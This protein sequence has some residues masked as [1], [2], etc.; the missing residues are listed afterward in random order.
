MKIIGPHTLVYN[1][2]SE[3]PI[4]LLGEQHHKSLENINV[5]E[6]IQQMCTNSSAT[7]FVER[8]SEPSKVTPSATNI[9]ARLQVPRKV[10]VDMKK[11]DKTFNRTLFSASHMMPHS[12]IFAYRDS[13]AIW[14]E[15]VYVASEDITDL[16]RSLFANSVENV[17]DFVSMMQEKFRLLKPHRQ[18]S[19]DFTIV[20]NEF[21]DQ[22]CLGIQTHHP[23]IAT[24]SN[25]VDISTSS[26]AR[27]FAV[28]AL[29][30]LYTM[31]S[32]LLADGPCV[33]YGG[34]THVWQMQWLLESYFKIQNN[35]SFTYH[36]PEVNDH[37]LLSDT[38]FELIAK[39]FQNFTRS[40]TPTDQ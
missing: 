39:K 7:L 1:T 31:E 28:C 19:W 36:D 38:V 32:I 21:R 17:Q 10:F 22:V 40:P 35:E 11:G 5:H 26:G 34:S 6:W 2:I 30:D 29:Q 12:D 24:A 20:K 27:I 9:V 8:F 3:K 33:F 18:A 13:L 15:K 23:K 25:S 4:L 37:I 14:M 16:T